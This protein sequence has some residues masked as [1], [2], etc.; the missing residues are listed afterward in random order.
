MKFGKFNLS[1]VRESR[2]RLDGGA[3][4]GV[5]PYTLWSRDV[6]VDDQNRVSLNC[7]LLLIETENG[8]VE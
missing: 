3:M 7:N 5:V 6:D 8:N 4:Y 2:F 1:I